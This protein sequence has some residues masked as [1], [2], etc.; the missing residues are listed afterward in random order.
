[1]GEI[2]KYD[3]FREMKRLQREMDEMFESFFVHP[4]GEGEWLMRSPLSD[5]ADK[6]DSFELA[7]ELPGMKKDDIEVEAD[8]NS[9]TVK[10]ERKE[11]E[12]EKKKDYYYCER[13]YSGYM[14]TFGLPEEIDAGSVDAEYKNGVLTVTMKKLKPAE[15]EKK[16]KVDIK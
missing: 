4:K 13:G 3:P 12:E 5:L 14:R 6:G 15:E 1:M 8:K 16:K 7:I 2:K 9:V 11:M 10:A